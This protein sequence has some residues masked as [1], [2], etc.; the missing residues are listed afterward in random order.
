MY[1]VSCINRNIFAR[2]LHKLLAISQFSILILSISIL[3]LIVH[4]VLIVHELKAMNQCES[5]R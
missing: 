3:L 2:L 5:L 4:L 1:Y